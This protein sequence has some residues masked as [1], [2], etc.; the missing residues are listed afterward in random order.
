MLETGNGGK[1]MERA[2]DLK[3]DGSGKEG[4]GSL[5]R[6]STGKSGLSRTGCGKEE[7]P[8]GLYG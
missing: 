2:K 7:M 1:V 6:I 5:Q 4:S 8:I 3:S